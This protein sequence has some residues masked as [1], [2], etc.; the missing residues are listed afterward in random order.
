MSVINKNVLIFCLIVIFSGSIRGQTPETLKI[1]PFVSSN[2]K[3]FKCHTDEE[4]QSFSGK[5]AQ[6][7]SNYCLTCHVELE[8]HHDVGSPLKGKLPQ[9]VKLKDKNRVTCY[10]CHDLNIK[11]YDNQSWKSESLFESMF[12]SKDK[13]QTFY[14]T[15]R[16][17]EGALC[18]KCH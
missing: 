3:C 9:D 8:G 7:C 1:M 16:N 18:K 5:T 15:I 13:H 17:N 2:Q 14:L 6:A 11:R 10:T 4:A 12:Q